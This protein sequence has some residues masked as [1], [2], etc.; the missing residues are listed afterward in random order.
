MMSMDGNDESNPLLKGFVFE[1]VLGE[2]P[3]TRSA[4]LL[5]HYE[6]DRN[7]REDAVVILEKTHF[8]PTFYRNLGQAFSSSQG[9]S[10]KSLESYISLGSNDVYRWILG[11]MPGGSI[12]QDAHVKLTLIRPASQE[13]KVFGAAKSHGDRDTSDVS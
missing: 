9:Q 11:W 10:S 4:A 7:G 8:S 3:K 13:H 12:Q 2:D 5:G 1:R 6:S